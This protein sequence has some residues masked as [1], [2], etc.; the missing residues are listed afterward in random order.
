MKAW[1][2]WHLLKLFYCKVEG[3]RKRRGIMVGQTIK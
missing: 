1:I 3:E 2:E